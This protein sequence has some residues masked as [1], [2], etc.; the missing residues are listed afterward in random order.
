[1]LL[2]KLPEQIE[3][4][5]DTWSRVTQLADTVNPDELMQIPTEMLLYRLFHEEDVRLFEDQH[6]LFNCTCT[7]DNVARMLTMLGQAEVESILVER[8]IIEV[9]CEFCNHRYE[10]D[11]VDA[12]QLFAA[13]APIEIART[14]H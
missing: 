12:V 5:N 14:R 11:K 9:Y 3:S 10:F 13:I 7:R 2:Q 4:D 1:M 6:V 8:E